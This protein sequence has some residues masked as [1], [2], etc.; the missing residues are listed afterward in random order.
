MSCIQAASN[1]AKLIS[2]LAIGYI[3]DEGQAPGMKCHAL[4]AYDIC[5]VSLTRSV[6]YCREFTLLIH[7]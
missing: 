2:L 7:I 6:R 5:E 3:V 4:P 1:L